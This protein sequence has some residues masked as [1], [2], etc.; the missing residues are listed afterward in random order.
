MLAARPCAHPHTV[1][2]PVAGRVVALDLRVGAKPFKGLGNA[3]LGFIRLALRFAGFVR[4]VEF[5]LVSAHFMLPVL[6]CDVCIMQQPARQV[7]YCYIFPMMHSLS[8]NIIGRL[9][10]AR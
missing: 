4:R 7:Y 3:R 2:D 6:C 1:D 8:G 5:E 9:L 10:S